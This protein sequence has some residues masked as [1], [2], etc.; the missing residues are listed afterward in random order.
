VSGK[1]TCRN[2]AGLSIDLRASIWE[3]AWPAVDAEKYLELGV[4]LKSLD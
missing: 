2:N 3:A 4:M 1:K